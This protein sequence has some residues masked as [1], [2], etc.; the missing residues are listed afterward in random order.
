[1][2]LLTSVWGAF[3]DQGALCGDP[4]DGGLGMVK[5]NTSAVRPNVPGTYRVTYSCTNKRGIVGKTYRH[6]VVQRANGKR[7]LSRVS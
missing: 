7:A 4:I 3:H 1:M 5:G 6:I 2:Y